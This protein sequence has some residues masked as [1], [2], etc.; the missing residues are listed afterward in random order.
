MTPGV[1]SRDLSNLERENDRL[2]CLKAVFLEDSPLQNYFE[3]AGSRH[4]Q[5]TVSK[6]E[7]VKRILVDDADNFI[8][9][10]SHMHDYNLWW[11]GLQTNMAR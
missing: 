10:I 8:S 6:S 2:F 5:S 7:T 9:D 1:T 3:G 4:V 11:T